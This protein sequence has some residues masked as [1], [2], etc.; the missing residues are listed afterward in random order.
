MAREIKKP[1]V[2]KE[3][4]LKDHVGDVVIEVSEGPAKEVPM[5]KSIAH[6]A[7]AE[8][9]AV[10]AIASAAAGVRLISF[11]AWFQKAAAKNQKVKLSYKEAIE[12]HCKAVGLDSQSTEEA[13][14]A[15]LSHFGL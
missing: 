12:A 1:N 13:F 4:D 5:P 15:A 7:A 2:I 10:Q 9:V 6:D 3:K 8:K 14:D 11:N